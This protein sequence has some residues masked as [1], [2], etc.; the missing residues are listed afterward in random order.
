MRASMAFD[1][2]HNA[3]F[4]WTVPGTFHGW[5]AADVPS[6]DTHCMRNLR[7]SRGLLG[8]GFRVESDDERSCALVPAS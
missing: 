5:L 8:E 7:P 4:G 1:C 3:R 6:P 2:A